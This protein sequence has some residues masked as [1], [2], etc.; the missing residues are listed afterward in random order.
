MRKAIILIFY[1]INNFLFTEWLYVDT[2]SGV[3][4]GQQT[5]VWKD[6]STNSNENYRKFRILSV[7]PS[8]MEGK[9][10]SA[11]TEVEVYCD[12]PTNITMSKFK[13]FYDKRGEKIISEYSDNENVIKKKIPTYT[14]GYKAVMMVC[15]N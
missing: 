8:V 1:L 4:A 12:N 6:Y 2:A 11:T 9:I 10:N 5:W 7:M 15:N 14:P 13:Y 3:G